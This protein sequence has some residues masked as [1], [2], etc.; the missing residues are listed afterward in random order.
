[1]DLYSQSL[2]LWEVGT[3][4]YQPCSAE[5]TCSEVIK[6]GDSGA[7]IWTKVVWLQSRWS[8]QQIFT[9]VPYI[10]LSTWDATESGT[11]EDSW[12][13]GACSQGLVMLH[14]LPL[15]ENH[16]FQIQAGFEH[17]LCCI[18]SVILGKPLWLSFPQFLLLFKG[19][20]WVQLREVVLDEMRH[21]I[22]SNILWVQNRISLNS[23][24][25]WKNDFS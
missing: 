20:T 23:R 1:M 10:V 3:V 14:Q 25:N 21:V 11:D 6:L 22:M 4:G 8:I 9:W 17:L 12:P 19:A 13:H 15:P 5:K 2:Q 24:Q 16:W 18:S 7:K